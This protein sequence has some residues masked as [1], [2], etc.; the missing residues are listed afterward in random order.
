MKCNFKNRMF[1]GATVLMAAGMVA[2]TSA[3]AVQAA[4][5]S[6][7]SIVQQAMNMGVAATEVSSGT[8]WS[9]D[10]EGTLT[11]TGQSISAAN[12][13]SVDKTLIKKVVKAAQWC[14]LTIGANAF[15]GC[16]NLESIELKGTVDGYDPTVQISIGTEA[17]KGCSKF[18]GFDIK[19]KKLSI[20]S[21][22]TDAF[23]GTLVTSGVTSTSNGMDY[24]LDGYGVLTLGQN[25]QSYSAQI[26]SNIFAGNTSIKSIKV[27]KSIYNVADG[28]F[29]NCTNLTSIE[30][31]TSDDM[32]G[33]QKIGAN[34]FEN[35]GLTSL[36][37]TKYT[38]SI[39]S[40]AFKNCNSLTDIS[41]TEDKAA[42]YQL[43][44]L[45]DN[46]FYSDSTV[47]TNLTTNS[48]TLK[49]YDWAGSNRTVDP[50]QT[51]IAV[52]EVTGYWNNNGRIKYTLGTDGTLTITGYNYGQDYPSLDDP[53]Q[54]D[55]KAL[56]NG[57]KVKKVVI[58]GF[59]TLSMGC[60][61]NNNMYDVIKNAS[62]VEID[63]V[64]NISKGVFAN[65]NNITEVTI[66]DS[67]K[68]LDDGSFSNCNNLTT[69]NGCKNVN[70]FFNAF[71][72]TGDNGPK[73]TIVNTNNVTLIKQILFKLNPDEDM[74]FTETACNRKFK[75]GTLTI[76]NDTTV[77]KV[78]GTT[79][80]IDGTGNIGN[81]S[82]SGIS[83]T[84]NKVIIGDGVTQIGDKAFANNPG[85]KDIQGGSNVTDVADNAFA[86]DD[87]GIETQPLVVESK[88]VYDN[89]TTKTQRKNVSLKNSGSTGETT[90]PT[91][92]GTVTPPLT[93]VAE[94]WSY[95]NVNNQF[96]TDKF[97]IPS[98]TADWN[99]IMDENYNVNGLSEKQ[100]YKSMYSKAT[101]NSEDTV[102]VCDKASHWMIAIP[103]DIIL[104]GASTE[105]TA[106]YRVGIAGEVDPAK[107]V[108]VTPDQTV[109]LVNQGNDQITY[110]ATVDQ[111][112]TGVNG[113]DIVEDFADAEDTLM[114]GHIS[115][116]IK[117]AGSYKGN[118]SFAID[119]VD[120]VQG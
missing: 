94:N 10:D 114:D 103:K 93:P 117:R 76:G 3:P 112:V 12:L 57:A 41:L 55:V 96:E 108:T 53:S 11:V 22:G 38:Q 100:G 24:I 69:I 5:P 68:K 33:F 34:A 107:R 70:D 85:F 92:P 111:P 75:A 56:Q 61:N 62:S 20:S 16:S 66:P 86:M 63:N 19:S 90:T 106:D 30:Y 74:S 2:T 31:G 48:N 97:S 98:K 54:A 1:K 84:I 37:L 45:G 60:L 13:S 6:V 82:L 110:V 26:D 44:D 67:V 58:N 64:A 42:G 59:V 39:G 8:N 35:T 115:A 91:T 79:I 46:A 99:I 109:T 120:Y 50:S 43:K 27:L 21:V 47:A 78:D 72:Y 89:I 80:Q 51:E 105:S 88:A 104:D 118:M 52:E 71:Y 87:Y 14:S 83:G 40:E 15:E 23:S 7:I 49:A 113:F 81:D 95:S 9:L 18:K 77:K 28:A 25:R 36:S 101:S 116:T 102:V 73:E 17:F 65:L 119:Y 32:T 4:A 29:K